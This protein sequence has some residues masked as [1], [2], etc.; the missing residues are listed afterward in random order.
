VVRANWR[1]FVSPTDWS[2]RPF[3]A[4][5]HWDA[6]PLRHAIRAALAIGIGYAIAVAIPWVAHDYWILLTITVVL[7]GSFAQT[8]ERRNQR[9]AGTM[10]GSVVVM[11]LLSLHPSALWLLVAM[12]VGQALSQAFAIRRYIVTAIGATTVGLIEAHLLHAGVAPTFA[13]GERIADTLIGTA[14]A[15]GFSYVLP[16]W[17]RNAIP[18]LVNR[19]LLAQ[20]RHAKLALGLGQL[21]AVDTAPELDW[22]LARREAFDSLSALVQ[23]TQRS[24]FEPRAVRPPLEPLQRLQVH[25]YQMLAQLSAVKSML[26]LRRD[27]LTADMVE[28]PLERAT[29]RIDAQI[30]NLN[31]LD[32]AV[33]DAGALPSLP[34]GPV[35]LPDPFDDDVSPW[36]L[37][38]L[39]LAVGLAAQMRNDAAIVRNVMASQEPQRVGT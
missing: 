36:L 16:S 17:E 38:R 5:W 2:L 8:L 18:A 10:L 23:A 35:P 12:A 29:R 25:S 27:R 22:R 24:L 30:G 9:V 1:L 19:T 26:M 11:V 13:M 28:G 37:R 15:W 34:A 14:L 3:L 4:L 6:P 32:G 7:R 33:E 31:E 20:W 21:R 39:D